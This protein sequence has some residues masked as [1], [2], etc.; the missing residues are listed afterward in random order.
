MTTIQDYRTRETTERA[1]ITALGHLAVVAFGVLVARSM[2]GDPVDRAFWLLAASA[3]V[4]LVSTLLAWASVGRSPWLWVLGVVL[5]VLAAVVSI[6]A[7]SVY[8]P[9]SVLGIALV[10]AG[11]ALLDETRRAVSAP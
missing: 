10:Y 5:L 9:M 3:A 8:L 7:A 6:W 11:F 2:E 4:G 1:L